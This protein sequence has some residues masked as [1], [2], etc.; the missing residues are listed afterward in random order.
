MYSNC[1]QLANKCHWGPGQPRPGTELS[2]PPLALRFPMHVLHVHFEVVVAGE[3]LMAQLAFRHGSVRIVCQLVPAEH[4]LQAERQ[5]TN[6]RETQKRNAFCRLQSRNGHVWEM[7]HLSQIAHGRP[8]FRK[9]KAFFSPPL[10]K[11]NACDLTSII[12]EPFYALQ[13]APSPSIN[14]SNP[15]PT[16]VQLQFKARRQ[17]SQREPLW[18]LT[19]RTSHTHTD[20][21][22][23]SVA[24]WQT[25]PVR[26]AEIKEK[27]QYDHW[28]YISNWGKTFLKNKPLSLL[29]LLK[30][31]FYIILLLIK[32]EQTL[33]SKA[34][35]PLVL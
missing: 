20:A 4:L 17:G 24:I 26:R 2:R 15:P 5:V 8:D 7:G 25:D 28:N 10:A 3:L 9:R 11:G 32:E 31:T 22:F 30:Y 18:R 33:N 14:H 35:I 1:D 13:M 34:Q 6:L 16:G 29:L 21:R 19:F 12:N 23:T 27:Y